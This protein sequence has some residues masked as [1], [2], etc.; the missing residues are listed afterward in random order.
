MTNNDKMTERKKSYD[1]HYVKFFEKFKKQIK[2]AL[3]ENDMTNQM[4]CDKIGITYTFLTM[5]NNYHRAMSIETMIKICVELK[6]FNVDFKTK[7]ETIIMFK[8]FE[9]FLK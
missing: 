6:M 8:M 9:K 7:N 2:I 3:I 1:K 4:L 5:C